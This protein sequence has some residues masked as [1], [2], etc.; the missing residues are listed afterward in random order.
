MRK[1]VVFLAH[2]NYHL[3]LSLSI[4]LENFNYKDLYEVVILK[5]Y[6]KAHS[7]GLD[8]D[9]FN[10][11]ITYLDRAW[12]KTQELPAA[13]KTRVIEIA[14]TE[15][16][17]FFL[18][19]EDEF[20]GVYLANVL[21]QNGTEI[22]LVQDGLKAYAVIT[23]NALRYRTLRSIEF[24]KFLKTNGF[25]RNF[26]YFFNIHYGA[27]KFVSKLWLTY[28]ETNLSKSKE[29]KQI[30]FDKEIQNFKQLA[31]AFSFKWDSALKEQVI[32]F[33]SSIVKENDAVVNLE[34]QIISELKEQY[35]DTTIYLK[36]HPR[37]PSKVEE[38]LM[39]IDYLNIIKD[40]APAEF[41]LSQLT[42]SILISAYSS[43]M[44]FNN[45]TCNTYWLLPMY[46]KH[47]PTFSYT[48]VLN[49]TSHIQTV[50]ALVDI[51]FKSV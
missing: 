13:T 50:D 26:W 3:L 22:G 8:L 42:N 30:L 38:R 4:V 37:T 6:R 28:P 19:N 7:E 32:F 18:F 48:K 34:L 1:R 24:Y 14:A 11:N 20:I 47:I 21:S 44:L 9:L 31:A 33:I 51:E 46:Q 15:T 2:S 10:A 29:A 35:P 27:A 25:K 45:T 49:P 12:L 5:T 39:E 16:S 36:L 17:H 41:Y 43:A 40:T 23:K